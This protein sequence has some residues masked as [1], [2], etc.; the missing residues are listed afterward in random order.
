MLVKRVRFHEAASVPVAESS[1]DG[2]DICSGPFQLGAM[3]AMPV[4]IT[5]RN[6]VAAF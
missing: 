5:R 3:R 4:V 2:D 6:H 1:S